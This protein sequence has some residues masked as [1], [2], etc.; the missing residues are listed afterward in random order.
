MFDDTLTPDPM[1]ERAHFKPVSL[2]NRFGAQKVYYKGDAQEVEETPFEKEAAKVAQE[3]FEYYEENYEPINAEFRKKVDEMDSDGAYGFAEGAARSG[4]MAKFGEAKQ[5][6]MNSLHASGVNPNSGRS[7]MAMSSLADAEAT[8]AA[9]TSARSLNSQSDEHATGVAN[10]V[11]IGNGEA[12]QAQQGLSGLAQQ[13]AS[14]AADDA[15]ATHNSKAAR[16]QAIGSLAGAA[17]QFGADSWA[18]G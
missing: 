13:S 3:R 5:G 2:F 15:Y 16:N 6:V 14:K 12:T 9:D 8:S 10:V 1:E 18:R 17:A 4:T 11:A 7:K